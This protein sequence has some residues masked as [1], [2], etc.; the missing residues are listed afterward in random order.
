MIC[1]LAR[2]VAGLLLLIA[3]ARAETCATLE[4]CLARFAAVAGTGGGIGPAEDELAQ[5]VQRHGAAAIQPLLKLLESDQENVR[6]LACYTL[7]DIDGLTAE[8]LP[9]LI[10][11]RR[12]GDGWIPPA[13]ARIGTPEAVE[14][15]IDDLRRDPETNTQVTWA[16]E[17]LGAKAA[18]GV[19][20]LLRCAGEC[21]DNV[22]SAVHF[23][24]SEMKGNA[25]NA[26]PELLQIARNETLSLNNRRTAVLSLGAIGESSPQH[27]AQLIMLGKEVPVLKSA[28]EVALS[29]MSSSA[30]VPALVR[31]LP[32]DPAHVLRVIAELGRNGHAAGPAVTR[33]LDDRDW[34]VRIWAATALGS[35]GYEAAEPSLRKALAD[36]DDWKLVYAAVLALGRL[37]SSASLDAL[38][39]VRDSHWYPPVRELAASAI[40]HVETGSELVESD[41]WQYA[42]VDG[43]PK[44]C[45]STADKRAP[46]SRTRK[47]YAERN[48]PGLAT[49]AYESAIR[50]Y[51]PPADAKPNKNGVIVMTPDNMQEHVEKIRQE[52]SVALK[53]SDGWLVGSDRGEWGGELVHLPARGAHDLVYE[54]NVADIFQLGDRLVAITGNAHMMFNSG[55]LLRIEKNDGGRYIATPWKR[56]PAAPST[57]WLIGGDRLLIN[58]LDGGTVIVDAA[59]GLRMAACTSIRESR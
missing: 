6:T 32:A 37:R 19:A 2:V 40:R 43:S 26:V 13:I 16:L 17:I 12:N 36:E 47:L 28:V 53:V 10:R 30:A 15:L 52:P 29:T 27:E 21:D 20:R 11:A 1:R 9:A 45:A 44:T 14:F 55:K 3:T 39:R 8:H 31:D 7:R 58:T 18:P 4:A 48:D 57:S 34:E 5:A 38:K 24:F 41:F 51:G 56:L 54:A 23:M 50:S 33:Y 35:I 25:A 46:E 22:S 59:G 49:L 42:P